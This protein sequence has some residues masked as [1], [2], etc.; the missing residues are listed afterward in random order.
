LIVAA[1]AAFGG[2]GAVYVF[3]GGFTVNSHLT[4]ANATYTIVGRA[5]DQLGTALATA[6]LDN[7]GFREIVIGAG[8][9]D[10][11]YVIKGGPSLSGAR[12]LS[13]SPSPLPAPDTEAAGVGIGDVLAAGDVTGDGIADLLVGASEADSARGVVYLYKG[14]ASGGV[15]TVPDAAFGAS[16]AGDRGGASIRLLDIDHDGIRDVIIGAPGQDGPALDRPDAGAV[17]LIW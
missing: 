15:P 8:G 16:L 7:D 3:L 10:R 13:A 9:T 12:D 6:D 5:G 11:F 17:Y 1:P 14:R 2:K 4:T